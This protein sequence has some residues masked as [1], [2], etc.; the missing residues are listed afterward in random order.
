[1][2]PTVTAPVPPSIPVGQQLQADGTLGLS[3]SWSATDSYPASSSLLFTVQQSAG[4]TESSLGTFTP[5]PSLQNL[6]G[7]TMGTVPIAPAGPFH[8]LRVEAENELGVSADSPTGAPFQLSVVDDADPRLTYD[9]GWAVTTDD[10]A[11]DGKRHTATAV[12]SAASITFSGH[13]SPSSRRL[14]PPPA[15]STSASMRTR[16]PARAAQPFHCARRPP[17]SVTSST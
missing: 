10:A 4:A 17:W 7:T 1:V 2:P 14:A 5:V 3:E 6:A 12:G 13:A 8:Q 15:R 9:T 16:R 11:F